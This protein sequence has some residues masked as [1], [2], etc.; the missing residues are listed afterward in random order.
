MRSVANCALHGAIFIEYVIFDK[1]RAK[2]ERFEFF[3][4]PRLVSMKH[5]LSLSLLSATP[6]GLP[7][8]LC[9]WQL[10]ATAAS[11]GMQKAAGKVPY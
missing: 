11:F 7:A 4:A 2:C 10:W 3:I 8:S 1:S 9:C 6:S 5:T